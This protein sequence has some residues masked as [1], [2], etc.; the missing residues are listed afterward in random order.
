MKADRRAMINSLTPEERAQMR[1]ERKKT[2][3]KMSPE[4]KKKWREEMHQS[5]HLEQEKPAN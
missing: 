5:H 2:F 1:E 3:E 4:E